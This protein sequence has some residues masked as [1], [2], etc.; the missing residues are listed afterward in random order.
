VNNLSKNSKEENTKNNEQTEISLN[1]CLLELKQ[2]KE[3]CEEYKNDLQRLAAEFDNYK[4]RMQNQI[5]NYQ[6]LGKEEVLNQLLD[7]YQEVMIALDEKNLQG[8]IK[9][10]KKGLELIKQ[11]ILNLLDQYKIKE[12][13]CNGEPDPNLHEVILQVEGEPDGH[14]AQVIKKG[15]LINGK[16]LRPAIVS[17]Y[18]KTSNK[19]ENIANKENND[20]N[21]TNKENQNKNSNKN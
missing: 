13:P 4:K 20:E 11:K 19:D 15:Y 2:A 21:T 5:F 17:V 16:L 14:I 1:Q 9:A 7:I 12:I 10:V 18:K 3:K 6:Q 8:D